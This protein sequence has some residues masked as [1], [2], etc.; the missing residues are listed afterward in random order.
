MW[1]EPGSATITSTYLCPWIHVQRRCKCGDYGGRFV[2]QPKPTG[3]G[4]VN[5]INQTSAIMSTLICPERQLSTL[6]EPL[7]LASLK[8]FLYNLFQLKSS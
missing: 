4:L 7:T 6:L 8:I 3:W 1:L 5:P 2:Y